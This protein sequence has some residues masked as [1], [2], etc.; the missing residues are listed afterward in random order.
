MEAAPKAGSLGHERH[1]SLSLSDPEATGYSLL[2]VLGAA[3]AV[4][5]F[6]DLWLLWTPFDFGN[7]AW[8]FG[9]LSR[10]FDT[11]PMTALGL[12]L[13]GIGI[14]RHPDA[15]PRLVRWLAIVFGTLA[16]VMVALA[17]LYVL[18]VPAIVSQAPAETIAALSEAITKGVVEVVVYIVAL[19]FAARLLWKGVSVTR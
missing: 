12:G 9:T 2:A 6:V 5:G 19:G 18:A 8:E 1:A 11:M 15:K 7:A 17:G 14:V 13:L 3:F 16:A 4:I 10:M